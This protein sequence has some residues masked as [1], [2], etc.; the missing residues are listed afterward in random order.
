[1]KKQVFTALA[2]VGLLS[3]AFGQL[4]IRANVGYNLP[5]NAQVIGENVNEAYNPD[6]GSDGSSEVVYGSYGS[7]LALNVAIGGNLK[8]N[9][10][11]DVEVGYV[12]GKKY[13]TTYNYTNDWYDYHEEYKTTRYARSFQFAPTLS[14]TAGT[15][16]IQPYTRVGPVIAITKLTEETEASETGQY[17]MVT[18]STGGLSVGFKG[19]LGVTFNADSKIQFF[20]ETNLTSLAYAPTK[21]EI[22]QYTINGNDA[23]E[24]LSDEQRKFKYKDEIKND[25]YSSQEKVKSALGSFGV[26]AGIKFSFN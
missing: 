17:K 23:L 18:E 15:G 26:Q 12:L 20:I 4:Y 21:G 13:T 25:D 14:F 8:G 24:S 16:S 1:M 3:P 19:A 5:M 9:L 22:T 10:G 6:F 7:G 2:L 11:Y